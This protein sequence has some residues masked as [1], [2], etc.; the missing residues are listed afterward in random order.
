MKKQLQATAIV[1]TGFRDNALEL[2]SKQT[3]RT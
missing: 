3:T 2:P 1:V